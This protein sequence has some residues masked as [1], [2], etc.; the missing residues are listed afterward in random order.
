MKKREL[1]YLIAYVIPLIGFAGLH[2]KEALSFGVTVFAFV[3]IPLIESF[4]PGTDSNLSEKEE[5]SAKDN[6]YFD[7]LLYLHLPLLYGMLFYYFH[8]LQTTVLQTYETVGLTLSMGV[9][10]G[11]FGI[12]IAHELGHRSTSYEQLFAKLLLLPAMYMH[13]NIEHN[14]GHHKH[15]ATPKDPSSARKGE[16]LYAFWF[17]SVIGVYVGAWQLEASRL[18]REGKSVL[19]FSNEMIWFQ[20]AQVAYLV[21]VGFF[22]GW[23]IVPFAIAIAVTGFLLLETVNYIE[24][25]GLSRKQLKSG[26]Y[27]TV[28]PKH[29]WNANHEL[30]RIVLYELTRH[31]DHHFKADRKYQILR[32]LE[33][34]PQ[35]PYG[36]PTSMLI[37]MVPPVWFNLMDKRLPV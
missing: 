22:F 36:Y 25:Y 15:V 29:S 37:A 16:S 6:F 35:L 24:H 8:I 12:N 27:E 5:V 33:E 13:F 21:V 9:I 28:L 14:R 23:D 32:H 3:L 10:V 2:Y 4:V 34:S 19:S 26:R 17:R 18:Q 11:S 31:S 20:I 30:G 1:K 7:L